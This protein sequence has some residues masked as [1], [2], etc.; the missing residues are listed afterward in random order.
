[1][2]G[3]MAKLLAVVGGLLAESHPTLVAVAMLVSYLMLGM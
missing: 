3:T 2:F 1:M